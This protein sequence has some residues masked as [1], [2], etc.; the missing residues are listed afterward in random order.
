MSTI[1]MQV[2]VYLDVDVDDVSEM[3]RDLEA[4]TAAAFKRYV[5]DTDIRMV[6]VE[7][8]TDAEMAAILST[9]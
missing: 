9:R 8:A 6:G 5:A 3:K 7:A 2:T 4:A 1:Q